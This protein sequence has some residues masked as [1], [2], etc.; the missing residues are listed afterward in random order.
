MIITQ[1]ACLHTVLSCSTLT[2]ALTFTYSHSCSHSRHRLLVVHSGDVDLYAASHWHY[3][4]SLWPAQ[5]GKTGIGGDVI[6]KDFVDP[7]VTV[8]VT[9]GELLCQVVDIE[10]AKVCCGMCQ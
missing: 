1:V 2:L 9:S 6:A 3:Y 4:E 5:V 10:Y 7:S 8:H